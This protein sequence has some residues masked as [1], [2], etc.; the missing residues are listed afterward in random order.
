MIS[1]ISSE[2]A[3]RALFDEIAVHYSVSSF[4]PSACDKVRDVPQHCFSQVDN[5]DDRLGFLHDTCIQISTRN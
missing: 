3:F 1:V 4:V 2:Q 5:K